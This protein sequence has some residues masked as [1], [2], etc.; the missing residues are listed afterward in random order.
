MARSWRA[1]AAPFST[2]TAESAIGRLIFRA[3]DHTARADTALA[4]VRARAA[5]RLSGALGPRPL[6]M[7]LREPD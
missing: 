4:L 6:P 2:P 5:L 3:V 1:A 7:L